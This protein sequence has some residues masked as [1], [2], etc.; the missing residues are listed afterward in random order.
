MTT[1]YQRYDF[2]LMDRFTGK[3]IITAGGTALVVSAGLTPK[4]TLYDPLNSHA[5]LTNPIS[6]TRGHGTFEVVAGTPETVDVYIMGPGGDFVVAL[7]LSPL[8]GKLN[9]VWVDTQKRTQMLKLPYNYVNM[10]L[11]T[12]YDTGFDFPTNAMVYPYGMGVYVLATD[13]GETIDVGPLST[14]AG[15]DADGFMA[16]VPIS[17]SNG[18]FREPGFTITTTWATAQLWGALVMYF[19]AGGS[20]DDRGNMIPKGWIC[21]GTSK[22][23]SFTPST[24]DTATGFVFVPYAVYGR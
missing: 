21:D 17:G 3:A 5:A 4:S 13:A 16:A 19:T 20:A 23:L 2:Q 10:P 15:G 6:L 7:G 1:L 9:P 18:T 8:A 24:W 11:T 12:E 14:E 22:S